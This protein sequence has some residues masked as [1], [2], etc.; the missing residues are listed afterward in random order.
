MVYSDV[1][2][3]LTGM[4]IEKLTGLRLDE[5]V[6]TSIT[7]PLGLKHTRYLP[8]EGQPYDTNNI[9]PTELC[10]MRKYR[11][12]GEVH[13]ES[14]WRLGGIAGHAGLFSNAP[15]LVRFGEMLLA[16]GAPL[17]KP[18][19]L[20]EMT[21]L[22]AQDG[23]MRRGIGFTLRSPNPESYNHPFSPSSFGHTGFTGTS[24]WVDPVAELAVVLLTNRVYY[25]R[26][27]E[28]INRLRVDFHRAV[29]T[30]FA[31]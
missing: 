24:I 3:I 16:G 14:T 21:A 5:A 25:G 22:Q 20:A 19:T 11:V 10:A 17:L 13:D 6:R 30:I 26:D 9:A 31:K 29:A 2:L 23:D 12:L 27:A 18:D 7:A 8:L 4:A 28:A 1:G 15:D